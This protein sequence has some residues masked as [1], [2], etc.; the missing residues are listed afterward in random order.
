MGC[1]MPRTA[2]ATPTFLACRIRAPP[3]PSF[4][5][6][7]YQPFLPHVS[8]KRLF[9]RA[10]P[11]RPAAWP[12]SGR[13]VSQN[14]L[15]KRCSQNGYP[16][17]SGRRDVDGDRL[18]PGLDPGPTSRAPTGRPAR[19]LQ[20]ALDY[21]RPGDILVVWKLDRLARSLKQR[22]ETIERLATRDIGFRS[23]TEA[24]ETATAG[25][26]LVCHIFA[27]LAEFERAIIRARTRAGLDAA[28]TRGRLGGRPP[29]LTA[30]ARTAANAMLADRTLT[31]EAV[32]RQ[33]RVAP[34]TLYRHLPGGQSAL[35][36]G[37]A[38]RGRHRVPMTSRQRPWTP[39]VSPAIGR[40]SRHAATTGRTPYGSRRGRDRRSHAAAVPGSA[41]QRRD[42]GGMGPTRPRGGDRPGAGSTPAQDTSAAGAWDGVQRVRCRHDDERRAMVRAR[43]TTGVCVAG[44]RRILHLAADPKG[45][46]VEAAW[47]YLTQAVE[48]LTSARIDAA[49]ARDNAC[50]NRAD[51]ACVQAA[52]AALLAAG[53]RPASPRGTWR[54]ACV[55]SPLHGLVISRRT[56]SPSALRRVLRDTMAV[57]EN[58]DDTP[59]WGSARVA[60]RVLQ[61]AQALVRAIQETVR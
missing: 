55:Q 24:I 17:M 21:A 20:A 11:S 4:A 22:I 15:L 25:G 13:V 31:V 35:R 14:A 6:W 12:G 23:L 27:S 3:A 9:L 58:A 33:L 32:A 44:R 2:A 61:A 37:R 7:W 19:Q 16:G 48:R 43:L 39:P 60:S 1:A 57:R 51:S 53:I 50:A 42:H 49:A 28:R 38:C 34:S 18:C 41:P 59:A 8:Q 52:I 30:R 5:A 47:T 46:P 45:A 54:Q 29:A 40:P 36:D 56:R 26:R 10:A